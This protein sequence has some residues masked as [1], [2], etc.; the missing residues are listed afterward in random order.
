MCREHAGREAGDSVPLCPRARRGAGPG[1]PWAVGLSCQV[2]RL[3]RLERVP[4]AAVGCRGA[5]PGP[6]RAGV[7]GHPGTQHRPQ[8][9]GLPGPPVGP[10]AQGTPR[11]LVWPL[12]TG[13]WMTLARPYR[14]PRPWLGGLFSVTL[15]RTHVLSTDTTPY[16]RKLCF[17]GNNSLLSGFHPPLGPSGCSGEPVVV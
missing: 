15:N 17:G 6:P 7:A 16:L 4:T 13:T 14:P 11:G 1:A 12:S 10:T 8:A 3:P 9:P 2:P 5:R